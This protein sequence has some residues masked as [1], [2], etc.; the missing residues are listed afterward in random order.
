MPRRRRLCCGSN[1]PTPV[2]DASAQNWT[3]FTVVLLK[4]V[5]AVTAAIDCHSPRFNY[6]TRAM[7]LMSVLV[8]N[9]LPFPVCEKEMRMPEPTTENRN[10]LQGGPRQPGRHRIPTPAPEN[11]A[12]CSDAVGTAVRTGLEF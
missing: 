9:S 1:R 11:R 3:S 4:A 8:I 12:R 2:P 6:R 5:A 7:D 10:Y